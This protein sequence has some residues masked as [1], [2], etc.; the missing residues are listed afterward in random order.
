VQLLSKDVGDFVGISRILA[1]AGDVRPVRIDK[2]VRIAFP[3][4]R[5]CGEVMDRVPIFDSKVLRYRSG[6]GDSWRDESSDVQI[7]SRVSFEIIRET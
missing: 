4:P 5:A 7:E 1:D 3:V 2:P 6:V